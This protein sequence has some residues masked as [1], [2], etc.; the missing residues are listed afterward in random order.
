VDG[1]DVDE[2]VTLVHVGLDENS[3]ANISVFPNPFTSEISITNAE[4]VKRVIISNIIGEV[5]MDISL[6]QSSTQ[7]LKTNLHSGI[8]LVTIISKDGSK[9]TRKMIGK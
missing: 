6:A 3:L 8:Y 4:T 1:A 5:V 7:K 9:V 2:E